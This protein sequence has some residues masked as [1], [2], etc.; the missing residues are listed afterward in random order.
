MKPLDNTLADIIKDHTKRL[1]ALENARQPYIADWRSLPPQE[2]SYNSVSGVSG[3]L[4]VDF[5][6]S[7]RFAVGDRLEIVQS[8][9]KY[10]VVWKIDDAANQ[11]SISGGDDYTLANAVLDSIRF[12]KAV[13]PTGFPE[14]FLYAPDVENTAGPPV[15]PSSVTQNTSKF[16]L[17]GNVLKVYD[18]AFTGSFPTSSLSIKFEL[19]FYNSGTDYNAGDFI[20]LWEGPPTGSYNKTLDRLALPQWVNYSLFPASSSTAWSAS[21][22]YEVIL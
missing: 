22:N 14:F 16:T 21:Y 17:T 9:T 3:V 1:V 4:D 5:T 2:F 6:P 13:A 8:T 18:G 20:P 15:P 12:S 11:I 7:S 19:P 10:F